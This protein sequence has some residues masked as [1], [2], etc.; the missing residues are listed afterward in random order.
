M[1]P[2]LISYPDRSPAV[3]VA[4]QLLAVPIIAVLTNTCAEEL[5]EVM[6]LTHCSGLLE[7]SPGGSRGG[8]PSRDTKTSKMAKIGTP[9]RRFSDTRSVLDFGLDRL[10][11][12]AQ[13][14][15]G[16]GLARRTQRNPR[17]LGTK[18]G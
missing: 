11:P 18:R 1:W 16:V 3:L 7:R 5:S 13:A 2:L 10:G 14:P 4:L 15:G 6:C 12:A 17:A 8:N 9:V